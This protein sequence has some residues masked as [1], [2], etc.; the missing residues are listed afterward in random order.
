MQYAVRMFSDS[1]LVADVKMNILKIHKMVLNSIFFLF[2]FLIWCNLCFGSRNSNYYYSG[3][4]I[5]HSELTVQC[6]L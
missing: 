1:N 2:T 3:F 6:W 4:R 5:L